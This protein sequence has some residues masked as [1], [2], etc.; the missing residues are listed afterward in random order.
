MKRK[1][2]AVKVFL[3]T[4]MIM[5]LLAG[6]VSAAPAISK[7][8]ITI[9]V[10]GKQKLKMKGVKKSQ[11]ITWKS[12][13]K[14]VASVNKKGQVKGKSKG[15]AVIT[16]TIAGSTKKYTCK[17]T[18]KKAAMSSQ[19]L[20]LGKQETQKLTLTGLSGK[21]KVKWKSSAPSAASV[22][23]SG[24]VTGNAVGKA[25]ITAEFGG[26]KFFCN[27]T[28]R[29]LKLSADQVSMQV[30]STFTLAV[31]GGLD[32]SETVNWGSSDPSVASV[33]ANGQITGKKAGEAV[34]TAGIGNQS[35]ECKVSIASTVKL[36]ANSVTMS[37]GSTFT[38]TL[39]GTSAPAT[40]KSSDTSV[41][42]VTSAGK[43]TAVSAGSAR[44]IATVGGREYTCS[45]NVKKPGTKTVTKKTT[46]TQIVSKPVSGVSSEET[47]IITETT[48]SSDTGSDSSDPSPSNTDSSSENNSS[49]GTNSSSGK[50]NSSTGT[51]SSSG[52][53]N[54]STGTNSSS[55]S[56]SSSG[57]SGNQKIQYAE[58]SKENAVYKLLLS[59]KTKYPEGMK[60]TNADYRSWVGGIY[61]GGYG[62]AGFCFELS[63]AAFAP[64]LAVMRTT[65]LTTGLKPG[66]IIRLDYNTHSVIVLEVYSDYVVV[67]E[68]N[69]NKSVHW[70][71][72]ITFAEIEKTGTNIIT[73]YQESTAAAI[74]AMMK[75]RDS[76]PDL[77]GVTEN[78]R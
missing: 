46:S 53:N 25:K 6:T 60:F 31:T 28:V 59:F 23:A 64:N 13:K 15:K 18:V 17:V 74:K 43:A 27:V 56:K 22:N 2:H 42:T 32:R 63:D 14:K 47:T 67:A 10:G 29:E 71:R 54:S 62:C 12:N 49:T 50:N 30:G 58:G 9:A 16:A 5:L 72:R 45:I 20:M 55:G 76:L 7:K 40:W 57:S 75:I 33:S 38:F 37:P 39:K 70:G 51:N 61:R 66:D 3:I 19:S 65:N 68:A 21:D 36:S 52:K 77:W 24:L 34:I 8:S 1:K 26:K 78:D 69:Y 41:V 35:L 44:I 73:R 4:W 48:D 11:K